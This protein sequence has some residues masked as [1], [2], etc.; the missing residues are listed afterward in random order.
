MQS[1]SLVSFCSCLFIICTK[2]SRYRSCHFFKFILILVKMQSLSL[3]SFFAC[4]F[5]ICKKCSHYRSCHFVLVYL[6]FVQ[7]A[8]A[9]ARVILFLFIYYLYKMQSLSLVSFFAYLFIICKKCS[10]YRSCHF[11]RIYL[12]FI[13]NA[14][15]SARII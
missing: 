13:K 14:V 5:I 8:V 15:A 3:V 6:L 10:R 7:N 11:F 1:L 2:C 4:L 9:I 12:L